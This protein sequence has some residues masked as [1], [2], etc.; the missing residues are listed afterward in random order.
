M[1][2]TI[3]TTKPL[4]HAN[5]AAAP[6]ASL[7]EALDFLPPPVDRGAAAE[8]PEPAPAVAPAG[9]AAAPLATVA[10]AAPAASA[11]PATAEAKPAVKPP[12]L[13]DLE[14]EWLAVIDRL[15]DGE[16]IPEPEIAALAQRLIEVETKIEAKVDGWCR[17]IS[18]VETDAEI[19]AKE[20]ERLA[21]RAKR[22]EKHGDRLREALKGVLQVVKKDKVKTAL[23][24][25]AV[26]NNPPSVGAIDEKAIPGRFVRVELVKHIEKKAILDEYRATKVAPPGVEV[27]TTKTRLEIK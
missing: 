17:F 3:P 25:V 24:S 5:R 11:S 12:S 6:H 27:I 9:P 19:A 14:H 1:S 4:G 18:R 15:D 23:Y 8:S 16:D 21:T 22:F 2:A 7:D 10:Q 20:A 13:F 26:R